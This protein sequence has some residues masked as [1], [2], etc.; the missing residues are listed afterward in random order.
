MKIPRRCD[1]IAHRSPT[2]RGSIAAKIL[3]PRGVAVK[4]K[5]AECGAD[6]I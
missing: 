3:S 5:T 2:E 1:R 4:L 6:S